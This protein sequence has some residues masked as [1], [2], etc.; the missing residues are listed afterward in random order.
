MILWFG[1]VL[2]G[3]CQGE[4]E[5]GKPQGLHEAE[6]PTADRERA[7]RLPGLDRQSRWPKSQS[8]LRETTDLALNEKKD[9][10]F[11]LSFKTNPVTCATYDYLMFSFSCLLHHN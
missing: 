3:V 2:Q 7:Q 1:L 5:G 11:T 8:L 4:G 6:T 10:Y 9:R